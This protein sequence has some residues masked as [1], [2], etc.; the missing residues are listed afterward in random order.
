MYDFWG[1]VPLITTSNTTPQDRPSRPTDDE[2]VKFVEDE[3]IAVSEILPT[4]QVQFPRATK[5]AA[6]GFLTRFYMN[7]HKWELAEQTSQD[8][9]DLGVYDLFDGASRA[10]LFEVGNE[11]DNEFLYVVP[12]SSANPQNTYLSHAAPDGYQWEFSPLTNF[13][14]DFHV[15]SS[16]VN[17]L[18]FLKT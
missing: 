16:F 8:I 3:F 6:L 4:Q 2:F 10:D 5:G 11:G 17:S 12:Y 18:I 14:A 9:I 1:P 7:N 15:T 13:A